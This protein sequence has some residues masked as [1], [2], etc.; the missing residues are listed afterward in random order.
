MNP[1]DELGLDAE[2]KLLR[3]ICNGALDAVFLVDHEGHIV[4]WNAAA[5]NLLGCLASDALGKDLHAVLTPLGCP[6]SFTDGPF[7][8]YWI[9]HDKDGRAVPLVMSVTPVCV[10]NHWYGL[11]IVH[12]A[13]DRT[14]LLGSVG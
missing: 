3:T 10:Q 9:A 11:G 13:V 2:E 7:P 6:D 8:L 4:A 5:E 1:E 14:N 12:Q